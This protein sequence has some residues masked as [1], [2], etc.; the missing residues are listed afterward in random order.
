MYRRVP[1]FI[2]ILLADSFVD[3]TAPQ[4]ELLQEGR[5]KTIREAHT[6]FGTPGTIGKVGER[7]G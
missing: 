7:D 1:G 5:D 2:N 6:Y 3:K 4:Y